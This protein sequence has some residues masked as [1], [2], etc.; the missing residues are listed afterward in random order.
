MI[1]TVHRNG[2]SGEELLRQVGDARDAVRV[3]IKAIEDIA[4]NARDYY[5]Q[6]GRAFEQACAEHQRRMATLIAMQAELSEIELAIADQCDA[7]QK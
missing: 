1:P 2:T 3:A 7:R 5:V 6:P 4:P